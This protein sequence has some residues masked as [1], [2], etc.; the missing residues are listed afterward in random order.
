MEG[1]Y[2]YLFLNTYH[3]PSYLAYQDRH[4]A[5]DPLIFGFDSNSHTFAIRDFHTSSQGYLKYETFNVDSNSMERSYNDM[6]EDNDMLGGIQLLR[7]NPNCMYPFDSK[8]VASSIADYLESKCSYLKTD[9]WLT[10]PVS[11][12]GFQI[13]PHLSDHMRR[14]AEGSTSADFRLI[15]VF[16]DHKLLMRHRLHFMAH[17]KRLIPDHLASGYDEVLTTSLLARSLALKYYLTQDT[18]L[19]HKCEQLLLD[20]Q[21]KER[22]A[23]LAVLDSLAAI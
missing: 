22:Q 2:I 12:Y 21:N 4:Y 20:L 14:V 8:L 10:S 3:L 9:N 6:S 18:M 19:L 11:A 7:I 13:Y 1:Y 15:H 23:L 16:H 5:H 17:N